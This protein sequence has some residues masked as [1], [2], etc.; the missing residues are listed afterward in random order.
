[1]GT[2]VLKIILK[3]GLSLIF[4]VSNPYKVKYLKSKSFIHMN[5]VKAFIPISRIKIA[6]EKFHN[7]AWGLFFINSFPALD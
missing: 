1:M 2:F 6:F 5:C 3:N 4:Q 7:L